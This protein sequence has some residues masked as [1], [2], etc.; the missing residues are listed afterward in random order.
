[1]RNSIETNLTEA[2]E[3]VESILHSMPALSQAEKIDICA[4]LKGA[5]KTIK[6]IDEAVKDEVKNTLRH[7]AGELAG[8]LFKACLSLIPTTRVD[9]KKL[10]VEHPRIYAK[11][12]TTDEVERINFEVR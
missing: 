3:A 5:A 8:D 10:E 2:C 9:L 1:M 12:Q 6:L 4:R 11:C 7:R